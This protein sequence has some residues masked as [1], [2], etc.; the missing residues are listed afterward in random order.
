M[1]IF[2]GTSPREKGSGKRPEL[3]ITAACYRTEKAQI[4][5][6]AGESAGKSAGKGGLLGG[7]LGAVFHR[8]RLLSAL[9]PAVP[10]A[11]PFFPA[12]FPALSPGLLGI[13][14]F[15]VLKQAAVIP[16]LNHWHTKDLHVPTPS[17]RQPLFE[18]SQF[19][20]VPFLSLFPAGLSKT[21][22]ALGRLS[23]KQ[24]WFTRAGVL[25]FGSVPERS[26]G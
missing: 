18:T 23:I 4:P 12:L 26:R 10:P 20:G 5:K 7:L 14:A 8:K 21:L 11:V 1:A 2:N 22:R 6:S 9:L 24:T 16:S 15:S 19:F 25:Y 13:W 17:V 3:G